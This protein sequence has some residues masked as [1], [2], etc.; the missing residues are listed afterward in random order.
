MVLEKKY[1]LNIIDYI[2]IV[3]LVVSEIL[4]F[5]FG[6][7]VSFSIVFM[8]FFILLLI[9]IFYIFVIL[10][11]KHE[12]N[13]KKSSSK[14]SYAHLRN[15][16]SHASRYLDNGEYNKAIQIYK[17]LLDLNPKREYVFRNNL[18]LAYFYMQ[19]YDKAIE[20]LMKA[21]EIRPNHIKT[22]LNLAWVYRERREFSKAVKTYE[23]ALDKDSKNREAWEGLVNVYSFDIKEYDKAMDKIK[24][25]IELEPENEIAWAYFAGLNFNKGLIEGAIDACRHSIEINPKY[26]DAWGLLG[27]TLAHQ[28]KNQEALEAYDK[29][30][31]IDPNFEEVKKLRKAIIK[32]K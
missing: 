17:N 15:L 8:L 12:G 22:Y 21:L 23:K 4:L 7:F 25:V 13:K 18:G 20:C 28:G 6:I 29:A 10:L 5:L 3:S 27:K 11:A 19:E 14:I 26:K 1:K 31:E 32:T 9:L 2:V 30:L 16:D 24:K